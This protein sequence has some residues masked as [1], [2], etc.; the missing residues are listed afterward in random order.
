MR[1]CV[2]LEICHEIECHSHVNDVVSQCIKLDEAVF[3]FSVL[4]L[5]LY[6]RNIS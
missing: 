6:A 5:V 2:N 3:V 1:W 4:L